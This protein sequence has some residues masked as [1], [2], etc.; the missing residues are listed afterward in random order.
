MKPNHVVTGLIIGLSGPI[1]LFGILYL[2]IELLG[3][4]GGSTSPIRPGVFKWR[5]LALISIC[6][7]ILTVNLM[8]RWRRMETV[9]GI[10]LMTAILG[11]VWLLLFGQE[12]MGA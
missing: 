6:F 11:I 2:G 10:A 5:T 9:R 1:L 4:I 12:L 7:N 3:A 8:Q